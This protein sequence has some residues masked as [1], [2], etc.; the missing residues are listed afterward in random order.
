[1]I[2]ILAGGKTHKIFICTFTERWMM[3]LDAIGMSSMN[4]F[5]YL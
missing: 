1:M 3:Q 2:E 4:I 5:A